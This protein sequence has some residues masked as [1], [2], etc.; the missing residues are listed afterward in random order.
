MILSKY[1]DGKIELEELHYVTNDRCIGKNFYWD[2]FTCIRT[3]TD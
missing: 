1:A 2:T 3:E